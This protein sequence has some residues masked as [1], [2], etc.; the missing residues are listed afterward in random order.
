MK[1]IETILAEVGIELREEQ[2]TAINKAVEENHKP[3]ADCQ[4]QRIVKCYSGKQ[5]RK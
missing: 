3:V 5:I 4:K 2:K 1:N